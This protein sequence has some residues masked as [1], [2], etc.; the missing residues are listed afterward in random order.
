MAVCATHGLKTW[1]W[2]YWRKA[3]Q[4]PLGGFV[5]LESV[6]GGLRLECGGC[7]VTLTR[8]CDPEV[9]R[10]LRLQTLKRLAD[11]ALLV[12]SPVRSLPEPGL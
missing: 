3:L 6:G 4:E 7:Q 9:L 12:A 11:L 10:Q 8:G 5:E 1:Q 2:A